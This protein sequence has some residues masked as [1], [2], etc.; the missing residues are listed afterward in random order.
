ME[1]QME[2]LLNMVGIT[3]VCLLA[4]LLIVT[5]VSS[6]YHPRVCEVELTYPN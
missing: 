1:K 4:V 5:V 3:L 2:F 6:V